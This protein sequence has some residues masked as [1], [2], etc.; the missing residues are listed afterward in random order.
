MD[1][2]SA[3]VDVLVIGGG[4]AGLQREQAL[5]EIAAPFERM[6]DSSFQ[7]GLQRRT[8]QP[9][10]GDGTSFDRRSRFP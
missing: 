2:V 9:G 8:F 7:R 3:S 1:S 6:G 4:V 10:H 5:R